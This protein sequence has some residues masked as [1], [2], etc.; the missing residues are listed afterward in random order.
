MSISVRTSGPDGRIVVDGRPRRRLPEW[1]KTTSRRNEKYARVRNILKGHGLH[2]VCEEASC[3]NI[4]ECWSE[5][6][7]T[8]MILGKYC[9]R[10]CKFCDV[11]TGKPQGVDWDE[12]A[13][14]ARV[15]ADLRLK[16]VVITCV[17]RDD[18]PDGGA[19]VFAETARLLRKQDSEVK[20]EFLVSDF[21]GKKES[22]ETVLDARV[23][24][25]A[26]NVETVGRLQ[27]KVRGRATLERS[28]EMLSYMH[29][30]R[31][32]PVVKT[33]FMLGLG[34]THEEIVELLHQVKEAGVDLVTIGQYLAPSLTHLPVEKFYRPEEFEEL[35]RIG[36]EIGLA[37]VEAGPLVRSSYRAF[38]QSR[39]LLEKR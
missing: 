27:R 22:L 30:Y 4:G 6:T 23:D 38:N 36:H 14:L 24:V 16:Q 32:R 21:A 11:L 19:A 37:H 17:T 31:P 2:S 3:P 13:R 1:I 34:E 5:G 20:I 15:V 18:L 8:F 33:G 25:M 7:A 12:P 29:E 9:T 28:L 39:K 35:A 10:N 26:H